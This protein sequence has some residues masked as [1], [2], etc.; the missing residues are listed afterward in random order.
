MY[1]KNKN[2]PYEVRKKIELIN[3]YLGIDKAA[4]D[5]HGEVFTPFKLINEMLDTL[6]NHVWGNPHLK[7]LD[8]ANGIG[9]FPAVILERLMENLKDYNDGKLD[10]RDERTRY[11]HIIEEMIYVCDISPKNMFLYLNIF[12]PNN[13]FDM[14]YH[15]GSF[16]ENNF[17]DIMKNWNVI[18]FDVVISNPPYNDPLSTGN[19]LW[20]AFIYKCDLL[21]N[22]DGFSVFVVPGRWVLP[23]FNIKKGKIRLWDIFVKNN[24]TYI[25]LGKCSDYFSAGSDK[26]YFSYFTYSKEKYKGMTKLVTRN[27]SFFINLNETNWLPYKNSNKITISIINKL[28]GDVFN[29]SWKYDKSQKNLLKEKTPTNNIKIFVG[30]NKFKFSKHSSANHNDKKIMFKLGR[31]IPYNKRVFIDYV[32]DVSYNSS[33]ISLIN[34]NENYDYLKSKLYY[35]LGY[36]LYNG[37]EITA[38]GYRTLPKI[39]PYRT[40]TDQ[41]LYDHFNL[42]QEEIDLIES[43]IK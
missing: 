38:E 16:L 14:K 3:S 23:G 26:D 17:K 33:Y 11:K 4:K 30:D 24:M 43:T 27:D 21:L 28:K 10:L 6:P 12:D 31:F 20:S 7:W 15:R 25:N 42:T 32:G 34:E 22:D 39:N 37:S 8:P 18:K 2:N 40:W 41:E 29:I 36:C 1:I 13:E 5:L 19:A 9:N 35:F